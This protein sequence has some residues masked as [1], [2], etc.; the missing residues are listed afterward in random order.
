MPSRT[1]LIL[2]AIHME[3]ERHRAEIDADDALRDVN[4]SVKL[5]QKTGLPRA[6]I[7]RRESE[8]TYG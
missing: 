3:M 5:N 7:V 6:T 2:Q 1:D 4:V 8:T